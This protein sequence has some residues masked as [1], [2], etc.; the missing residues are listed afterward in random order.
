MMLAGAASL[1]QNPERNV[2]KHPGGTLWGFA[3]QGGFQKG[4]F[5][6]CSPV[7]KFPPKSLFLHATLAEEGYDILGT[8]VKNRSFVFPLELSEQL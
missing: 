3:R 1:E 8:F 5:G 4:G 7:P 6:R 2:P